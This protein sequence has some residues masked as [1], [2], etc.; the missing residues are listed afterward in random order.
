[1]QR[2]VFCVDLKFV[3]CILR[4][5]LF[6]LL[7]CFRGGRFGFELEYVSVFF[8]V[9][10]ECC[11]GV[12][13]LRFP[14]MRVFGLRRFMG[15]RSVLLLEELFCDVFFIVIGRC[16]PSVVDRCD[17]VFFESLF[18]DE[19]SDFLCERRCV[20][21]DVYCDGVLEEE[22]FDVDVFEECE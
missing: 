18:F 6:P 14:R 19:F 2:I 4:W 16:V 21:V 20:F 13:P 11:D 15:V 8:E 22:C 17:G 12:V 9:C 5:L 1:M 3:L 10:E 7:F